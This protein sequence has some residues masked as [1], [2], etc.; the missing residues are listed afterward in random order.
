MGV[1]SKRKRSIS[2]VVHEQGEKTKRM[3]A[4]T[5]RRISNCQETGIMIDNGIMDSCKS[6]EGEKIKKEETVRNL[7]QK[8]KGKKV[9]YI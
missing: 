2:L 1:H 8:R 7:A 6:I 9:I 5:R 3:T 4:R